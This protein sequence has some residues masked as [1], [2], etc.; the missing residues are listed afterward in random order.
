[1]AAFNSGTARSLRAP[2]SS[3]RGSAMAQGARVWIMFNMDSGQ[4]T[5]VSPA[6]ARMAAWAQMAAAPAMPR[7]PATISRCP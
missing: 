4:A 7:E 3:G 6:P 5:V 1:M 2:F